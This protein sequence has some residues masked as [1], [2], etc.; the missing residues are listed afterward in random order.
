[1]SLN[2]THAAACNAVGVMANRKKR[3]S[4]VEPTSAP[5]A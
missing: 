2:L 4:V 3:V 5:G 1:M